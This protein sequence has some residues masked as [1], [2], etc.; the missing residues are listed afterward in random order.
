V[1]A[2]PTK[3]PKPPPP[4]KIETPPPPEQVTATVQPNGSAAAA[5][6]KPVPSPSNVKN[7]LG[8]LFSKNPMRR[9]ASGTPIIPAAALEPAGALQAAVTIEQAPPAPFH[10]NGT[11]S[12]ALM[13]PEPDTPV[14]QH[15]IDTEGTATVDPAG[16]PLPAEDADEDDDT[17][18]ADVPSPPVVLL[19]PPPSIIQADGSTDDL[20]L[21]TPAQAELTDGTEADE[22]PPETPAKPTSQQSPDQGALPDVEA[23]ADAVLEETTSYTEPADEEAEELVLREDASEPDHQLGDVTM[24]ESDADVGAADV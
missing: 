12:T 3:E 11:S 9:T 2:L 18:V 6:D 14:A 4:P 7:R 8:A 22:E 13:A 16:I 20:S 1:K 10:V 19:E 21:I 23:S 17:I 5:V 24:E 15:R